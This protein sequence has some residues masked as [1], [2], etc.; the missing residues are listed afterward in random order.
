[1][2]HVSILRC[3]T[4]YRG[5]WRSAIKWFCWKYKAQLYISDERLDKKSKPPPP[6][7]AAGARG[8]PASRGHPRRLG[9]VRPAPGSA[10]G[11]HRGA[12]PPPRPG[13]RPPRRPLPAPAAPSLLAPRSAALFSSESRRRT[14]PPRPPGRGLRP[15]LPASTQLPRPGTCWEGAQPPLR[16]LAACRRLSPTRSS[17]G[18]ALPRGRALPRAPA[19]PLAAS[20]AQASPPARRLPAPACP[21]Q[22]GTAGLAARTALQV[23]SRSAYSPILIAE[24]QFPR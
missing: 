5:C 23:C 17:C 15:S 18:A 3:A 19:R 2:A 6:P 22:P 8:G 13:A 16:P 7:S 9:V 4:S 24:G 12:A 1:M 11:R 10:G 21:F 20:P 14:A